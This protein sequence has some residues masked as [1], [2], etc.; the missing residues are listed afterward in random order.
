M[1]DL[2]ASFPVPVR[3][4]VRFTRHAWASDNEVLAECMPGD[5]DRAAR[6]LVVLDAGL[7]SA[8]PGI[9]DRIPAWFRLR[10]QGPHLAAQPL[11]LPGGEAAKA[12][13]SVVDRVM[14]LA[15]ELHLCRH[16]YIV[17][18]GGGALLD[19]VGLAAALVHRGLRLVRMPST[20]LGQC[21]AGLG[22]KN[23]INAYQQKNFLG[24]FQPPWA[25]ID[26][27]ALL[28]LQ[29]DRSWRAGI[30]EAVKVGVIKDAGFVRRIAALAPAI[31]AR[32]PQAMAEIVHR[33][34]A[35]HLDHIATGGDPFETGSSRPLDFGHW[36]AHRLEILTRHR[37]LHGEAVA[38]GVAIDAAYAVQSGWLADEDG[39]MIAEALAGVG[40]PL[41]DAA[42]DLR[43]GDGRRA[44]LGGLEQFRAHLGGHLTLA[45][46]DGLGR[47]QDI[48][49]IDPD[50]LERAL[51][52][53][54]R[55][56]RRS[57]TASVTG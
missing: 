44:I 49:A 13:W 25:V 26:D 48:H 54:G 24:T 43:D 33:C 21:D 52:L 42:L 8:D 47:R 22:V 7:V 14:D 2:T 28:D 27:L 3:F 11:I 35:L 18:M 32:D 1:H 23:A 19:A 37:L 10:D 30:A 5:G 15:A 53:V 9:V 50:R 31:A 46:P 34:A 20:T 17:A 29:D 16:S 57:A 55:W 51:A 45:M 40:L 38:I 56:R 4:Q 41:W 36:T 39:L 12:D 6:A